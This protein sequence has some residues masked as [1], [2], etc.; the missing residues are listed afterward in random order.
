MMCRKHSKHEEDGSG[1][2][3]NTGIILLLTCIPGCQMLRM[4]HAIFRTVSGS[5]RINADL[6]RR[7]SRYSVL[8]DQEAFFKSVH[9]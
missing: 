2:A 4:Q 7:Q 1:A 8:Q 5:D 6:L 9:A 3:G